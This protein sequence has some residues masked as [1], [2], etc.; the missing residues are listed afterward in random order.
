M[1]MG[2]L[3]GG[4]SLEQIL[5]RGGQQLIIMVLIALLAIGVSL[6]QPAFLS[7]HSVDNILRMSSMYGIAALGMTLVIITAGIDLSVG[8]TIALGGACGAGLLGTAF[9]AANPFQ[10]PAAVSIACAL[11]ITALVGLLNGLAITGLGIAPFVVTLGTMTIVR[12]FTYIFGDYVVGAIPGSPITF[13][14]P[15]FD[16]LGGASIG[17][18]PSSAVLFVA[19]AA[20]VALVLRYTPFGRAIYAIGGDAETAR[21]AG[22]N[23]SRTIVLVYAIAG[24]LAGL[25]GLILAGRLSSVSPLMG[26]GYELNVITIVVVGGASLAGG[27]GTIFGTVLAA[28]LIT[29]IDNGLDMMNVPSFYQYLV[30]GVVLLAAV[31][32]DRTYRGR[33]IELATAA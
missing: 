22:I 11:A 19:L 23:T 28:L 5:A 4:S 10:L 18:A 29:M 3:G 6:Y 9:G 2:L 24:M 31:I 27:R 14:N 7:L 8:S 32:A 1:E 16:W 25:S 15:A 13:S 30:R 17:P 26:V 12:G 21:L 20:V 33:Q